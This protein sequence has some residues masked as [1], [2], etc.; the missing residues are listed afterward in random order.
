[1]E[2][3]HAKR[4]RQ[5]RQFRTMRQFAGW[6]VLEVGALVIAAFPRQ[7]KAK[8]KE[9]VKDILCYEAAKMKAD[10]SKATVTDVC[11]Y[12]SEYFMVAPVSQA[13]VCDDNGIGIIVIQ[14]AKC[15]VRR[16]SDLAN[17]S[18]SDA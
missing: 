16:L 5:R 3:L 15:R 8:S 1:M 18:S 11:F 2:D 6:I 7:P 14:I 10:N 4:L 12:L 13:L 9:I 17:L